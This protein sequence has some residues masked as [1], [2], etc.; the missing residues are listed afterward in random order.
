MPFE[1]ERSK[2]IGLY[3]PTKGDRIR[4]AD[5]C[6]LAEIEQD[7]STYGDELLVGQGKNIRDGI[8]AKS[9]GLRE[10]ALDII[11]INAVIIDPVLGILKGNIGI[12]DGLIVGIGNAGNPDIKNNVDLV[13]DAAT[14][15]IPAEG[16]IVTPGGIDSHVHF[17]TPR[18]MTA[19]L[20]SGITTVIGGVSFGMWDIGANPHTMHR[21]FESFDQLPLNVGFLARGSVGSPDLLYRDIEAGA[22]GLKIHEDVAAHPAVID[23]CLRVADET[24]VQVCL[25]TDT[26][27]ESAQ[28]EDTL[29]AIGNRT[30]HAYH[31]EG[32]GGGHAPDVLAIVGK[33][34][35]ICSS[36][37]PTIPYT[38]NTAAEHLAMIM[39]VHRLN[40]LIA[41]DVAA[42]SSRVRDE[43][44][45]AEDVLHDMG[46][47]SI[48]SSDSQGMG[49]IGETILRTWQLADKMKRQSGVESVNDNERILRYIAKYT[50]N[51]AI[52]HGVA[53]YVGSLEPGK[54]ADMVLWRPGFFGVKPETVYKSGI[55][56]WGSLGD[57]NAT[58]RPCQPHMYQAQYGGLGAAVASLCLTFVSQQSVD[59]GLAGKT[60]SRRR[61]API[62]NTRSLGPKDMVR[63]SAQPQVEVDPRTRQVRVNGQAVTSDPVAEVP[64]NR[65][66]FLG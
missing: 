18:L 47:I 64:L 21:M 31:V 53:K 13:V 22:C 56:V 5:T 42:A 54:V 23:C 61:F 66:Y 41:E 24:G 3:G 12:K 37:N 6:L 55:A 60:K 27:N 2:Y 9:R 1:M 28:L 8:M 16:L 46:A 62:S 14:S 30:L 38:V 25:H 40:P 63:N 48:T 39:T 19:A 50:I 52:A 49:R 36:T 17:I 59:G 45:A 51:P 44:L 65:L 43:T 10:S 34:N 32:A 58:A 4:L 29:A 57:G 35:I 15:I 20:S 11:V 26:L 33:G 7:F